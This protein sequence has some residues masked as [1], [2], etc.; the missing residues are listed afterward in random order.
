MNTDIKY[1]DKYLKYKSKYL[2]LK[3][4]YEVKQNYTP[5]ELKNMKKKIYNDYLF[6]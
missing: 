6:V 4:L 3:D 2:N 1:K 5:Q